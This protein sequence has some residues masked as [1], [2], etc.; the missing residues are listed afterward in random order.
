VTRAPSVYTS[1]Y[2]LPNSLMPLH[3]K[4][5]LYGEIMSTEK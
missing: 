1:S 3:P 2:N 4:T 5:A